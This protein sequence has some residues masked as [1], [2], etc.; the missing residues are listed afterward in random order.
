MYL[1][2]C[3]LCEA[4][5]LYT[6][7]VARDKNHVEQELSNQKFWQICVE[8]KRVTFKMFVDQIS[9]VQDINFIV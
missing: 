5:V 1:V 8:V 9:L 2:P 7:L 4:I 6:I 3:F